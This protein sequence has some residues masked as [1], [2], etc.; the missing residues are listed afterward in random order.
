MRFPVTCPLCDAESLMT[1]PVARVTRT[2][3]LGES[4]TLH[5]GCHDLS[6]PA[7]EIEI[8]QIR[9]YLAVA[10][11]HAEGDEASGAARSPHGARSGG[12]AN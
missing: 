4:F 7:G 6:W 1:V 3:R 10:W 2:L 5:A 8:A 9:Q 11:L 12:A